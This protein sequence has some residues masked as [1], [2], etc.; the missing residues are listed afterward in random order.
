MRKPKC[1]NDQRS[2]KALGIAVKVGLLLGLAWYQATMVLAAA[3]IGQTISLRAGAN[4]LFVTADQNLGAN[5]PLVANRTAIGGWEQFNVVDAGGGLIALQSM[6]NGRFVS[7][8]QNLGAN[9]P[10]VANRTAVGG[11]ERFRWI[12]LS[13]GQINLQSVGNGR[14]V[15]ADLNL[16]S[17]APLVANRTFGPGL[18]DF[19]LGCGWQFHDAP[20]FWA[21]RACLQPLHVGGDHP[22][23]D[24]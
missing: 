24:Q 5:A 10:L 17:N 11:W 9:A 22:E 13:G 15:S 2:F 6:G 7:A 21:Q 23:P 16:A 3:P 4:S 8:D 18:G 12:E 20:G 14:F 19:Y 1:L